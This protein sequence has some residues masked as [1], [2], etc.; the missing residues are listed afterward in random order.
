MSGEVT[1]L[2]GFVRL[3][4]LKFLLYNVLPVGLGAAVAVRAGYDLHLG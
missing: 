1:A 4:R 2:Q 3:A